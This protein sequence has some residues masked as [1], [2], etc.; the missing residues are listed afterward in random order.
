MNGRHF[1]SGKG[2]GFDALDAYEK[3][4]DFLISIRASLA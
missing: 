3:G 4:Y 1:S 2:Y